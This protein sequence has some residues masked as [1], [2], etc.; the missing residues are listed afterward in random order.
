MNEDS[1]SMATLRV[2]V[3]VTPEKLPIYFG[4]N[5][6]VNAD[7]G[8]ALAFSVPISLVVGW[9]PA[10]RIAVFLEG[11]MTVTDR[12][13][14]WIVDM[15]LGYLLTPRCSVDLNIGWDIPQSVPFVNAGLT[16]NFGR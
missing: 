2:L 6:G 12:A 11:A 16:L 1:P 10:P 7:W 5:L 3:D 15:G 14:G 13:E 8:D 4:L 9:N